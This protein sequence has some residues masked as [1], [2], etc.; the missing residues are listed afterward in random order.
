M[1]E[2]LAG[3]VSVIAVVEPPGSGRTT[4]VRQICGHPDVVERFGGGI[5]WIALAQPSAAPGTVPWLDSPA[6]ADLTRQ[7]VRLLRTD[8]GR[9]P[10]PVDP[11]LAVEQ[12]DRQHAGRLLIV[13]DVRAAEQAAVFRG[14]ERAGGVVL[15]ITD[16]VSV[17]WRET[18][19]VTVPPM[20]RASH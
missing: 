1:L 4:L 16:D 5:V 11:M 9:R 14:F 13:D 7:I 3:E 19:L 10:E 18:V 17:L 2:A 12:F 20:E 8:D 6:A 15:L